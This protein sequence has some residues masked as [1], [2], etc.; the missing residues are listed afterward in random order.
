V[1]FI[2]S[3]V[4]RLHPDGVNYNISNY[5]PQIMVICKR[6]S[7]IPGGDYT[8]FETAL[9]PEKFLKNGKEGLTKPN[10]FWINYVDPFYHIL[11]IEL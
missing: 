7:A 5:K 2:S 10:P 6:L 11:Q 3:E 9:Q 4:E 1:E 8:V